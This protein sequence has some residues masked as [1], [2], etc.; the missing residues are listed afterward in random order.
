MGERGEREGGEGRGGVG[1]ERQNEG[2][3]RDGSP[4]R[5]KLKT[6]PQERCY[7]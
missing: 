5:W 1:V 2:G 7:T 3:G 4:A 6:R